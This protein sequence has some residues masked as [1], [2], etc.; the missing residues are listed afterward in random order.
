MIQEQLSRLEERRC[1]I[2]KASNEVVELLS[3]HWNIF[4]PGCRLKFQCFLFNH[5]ELLQILPRRPSSHSFSTSRGCMHL[6][7][8]FS[9]VCGQKVVLHQAISVALSPS[10]A[11]SKYVKPS[12]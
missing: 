1:P 10:Y 4:A 11:V 7:H 8:S 5:L 9:S 6:P 2:A 12:N 3:E